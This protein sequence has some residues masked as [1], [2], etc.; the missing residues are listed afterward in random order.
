[1]LVNIRETLEMVVEADSIEEA[2]ERWEKG[3]FVL[4]DRDFKE[5]EFTE[6]K[7]N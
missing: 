2:E 1:M 5:A 6:Y 7:G 4:N 3:E